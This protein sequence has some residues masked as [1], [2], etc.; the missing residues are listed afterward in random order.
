MPKHRSLKRETK[1]KSNGYEISEKYCRSN[2]K[3]EETGDVS[4]T[5]T[6]T[7]N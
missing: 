1:A 2:K 7:Q 4:P 6:Y 3:G 5:D